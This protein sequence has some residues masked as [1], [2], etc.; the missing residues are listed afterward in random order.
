MT[1]LKQAMEVEKQM[2]MNMSTVEHG[3]GERL[4]FP[5]MEEVENHLLATCEDHYY[6]ANQYPDMVYPYACV[7]LQLRDR[8]IQ[9]DKYYYEG[10]I[11]AH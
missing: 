8:W 1:T 3:N 9:L 4:S 2:N 6:R 10:L 7:G 11:Q 5:T